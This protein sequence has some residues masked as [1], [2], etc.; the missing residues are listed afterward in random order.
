MTHPTVELRPLVSWPHRPQAGRSYLVTVDVELAGT[1]PVP[2]WPYEQEEFAIGC[3]LAGC[4]GVEI[5]ALGATAVVLHRY[6]GTYGPARFA[7]H[8]AADFPLPDDPE[9]PRLRLN[10]VTAGGI[11]FRTIDLPLGTDPAIAPDDQQPT[12]PLPPRERE[13]DTPEVPAWSRTLPKWRAEQVVAVG[14]VEPSIFASGY[15]VAQGLVLTVLPD[16]NGPGTEMRVFWPG[17]RTLHATVVWTGVDRWPGGV[18]LLRIEGYHTE[19]NRHFTPVRWGVLVTDDVTPCQAAGVLGLWPDEVSSLGFHSQTGSL[20]QRRAPQRPSV[21]YQS[22]RHVWDRVG[23]STNRTQGFAVFCGDLLTGVMAFGSPQYPFEADIVFCAELMGDPTFRDALAQHLSRTGMLLEPVEWQELADRISPR[24]ERFWRTPAALLQARHEVLP[25]HGRAGLLARLRDWSKEPGDGT[26]LVHGAGGQG[27]TRLAQQLSNLAAADGWA[28]LWLRGDVPAEGLERLTRATVPTLIV[29]DYAETRT[30]QIAGLLEALAAMRTG[31]PFKLLLLARTTG[32][33]WNMLRTDT[34]VAEGGLRDATVVELPSAEVDFGSSVEEEYLRAV[35]GFAAALPEVPGWEEHDWPDIAGRLADPRRVEIGP[36]GT[37][38]ALHMTALVDLLDTARRIVSG[39][40]EEIVSRPEELEDRLLAHE[41]RDW[42]M[43]AGSYGVLDYLSRRNCTNVLA[44]AFMFGAEDDEQADALLHHVPGLTG[45]RLDQQ[46][47]VNAWITEVSPSARSRSW[48]PLQ[49]D[50]LNERF[51]GRHLDA[52][53]ALADHLLP[54][55]FPAQAARFVGVCARAATHPVF[56]DRLGRL[57]TELCVRH[58]PVLGPVAVD[59]ATRTEAPGPLLDALRQITDRP[60]TTL[61]ELERLAKHIPKQSERLA[62]WAVRLAERLTAEYRVLADTDPAHLPRLADHLN[63]LGLRLGNTGDLAGAL[64]AVHETVAIRR[65][66]AAADPDTHLPVLATGLSNLGIQL[67]AQNRFEEALAA[68]EE[69]VAIR[70]GFAGRDLAAEPD[71]AA[72]LSNLGIRYAV[73]GRVEA[74]ISASEQAVEIYRRLA[75]DN[76]EAHL[77]DLAGSLVNLGG[78]L[79]PSA[80]FTEALAVVSEAVDI[81]R[82]LADANPDAYLPDLV[83]GLDSLSTRLADLGRHAEALGTSREA[84][85]I[86]RQLAAANPD[87]HLPGL[88]T[89]LINLSVGLEGEGDRE[90]ALGAV[91]EAVGIHRRLAEV[92][93]AAH[94]PGLSAGLDNL[95]VVLYLL[96]RNAETV[97]AAEEAVAIR[98]QLAAADPAVHLPSLARALGLLAAGLSEQG[99]P[100]AALGVIAEAVDI[101]HRLAEVNPAVHLP[102]LRTNLN[103]QVVVLQ[104]LGR[105][106]EAVEVL[107]EVVAIQRQLAA[108]DPA[109]HLPGLA[110]ALTNFAGWAGSQGE[111]ET[112]LTATAEAID[113]YRQLADMDGAAHLLEQN[114]SRL[115]RILRSLGGDAEVAAEEA[116]AIQRQL[117]AATEVPGLAARFQNLGI[118]LAVLRRSEQAARA[119]TESVDTGG[120]PGTAG[121]AASIRIEGPSSAPSWHDHGGSSNG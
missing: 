111:R 73:I 16:G 32:D 63:D 78:E 59:V 100:D 10:L 4:P 9:P 89:S 117:A 80:R 23:S 75:S 116:A 70:R 106:A 69:A 34:Q 58:A 71:L 41:E 67:S 15:E 18:A 104:S 86:R 87:A 21:V 28:V 57:L 72:A 112:A 95:A 92:N 1:G 12:V 84:V 19:S 33:W 48:G 47:A 114:L 109:T 22:A 101:Q 14:S 118:R 77:P 90:A 103:I 119:R 51:V 50:R 113:S 79:G 66:L 7:A 52:D 93:P 99:A 42:L 55:V 120:R 11:P 46:M 40:E 68:T 85:A 37:V 82:G 8:V 98:R 53:P 17:G 2:E 5:E 25:F 91:A 81:Y 110:T 97:V 83:T 88:A 64:E 31:P 105:D 94:L 121:S 3:M 61:A 38:L 13:P 44:A 30:E 26:A 36:P 20:Q 6:G 115:V 102:E 54:A 27:K 65:T 74:A 45:L 107:R 43:L 49:P 76:P 60:G 56:E 96:D 29:V 35:H 108:A 62:F 24:H 39:V